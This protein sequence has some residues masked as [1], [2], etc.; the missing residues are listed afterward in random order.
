[1]GGG[2]WGGVGELYQHFINSLNLMPAVMLWERP[3]GGGIKLL[4]SRLR[5]KGRWGLSKCKRKQTG[6]ERVMAMRTFA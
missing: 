4:I 2:G 3:W 1:M 5:G 6:R